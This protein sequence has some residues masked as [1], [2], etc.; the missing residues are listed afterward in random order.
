MDELERR[1]FELHS[2][3]TEYQERVEKA[4]RWIHEIFDRY[5]NPCLNYSGGKDSLVLLH[6]VAEK[7][8]YSNVDIYHFDNGLLEVP[9]STSF[10]EESVSR[11]GGNLFQ[12]TSEKVNSREMLTEEGHGYNGFWGW[13]SYLSNEQN[14]DLRLVGIRAAESTERRERFDSAG[15]NPPINAG[16]E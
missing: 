10:V 7:C 12:R 11:I 4:K 14:W 2:Q 1:K 3:K 16:E 15:R 8:G 5:D 6:L 9:G 13:Y